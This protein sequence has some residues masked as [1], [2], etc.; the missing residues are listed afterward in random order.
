MSRKSRSSPGLSGAAESGS[1]STSGSRVRMSCE[2]LG[3]V[4]RDFMRVVAEEHLDGDAGEG[5][6]AVVGDV[7][8]EI[9]N[10]AAGKIGGL[11]HGQAG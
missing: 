6:A 3:L 5:L 11:A 4:L 8:V 1:I 9:G 10:L 2:R 7:A